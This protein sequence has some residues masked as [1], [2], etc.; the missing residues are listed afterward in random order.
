MKKLVGFIIVLLVIFGIFIFIFFKKSNYS[1]SYKIDDVKVHENYDKKYNS[2][3]INLEYKGKK[4]AFV[5]NSKYVNKRKLI[6]NVKIEKGKDLVCLDAESNY[7]DTYPVCIKKDKYVAYDY[8]NKDEEIGK[9]NN[10][11]IYDYDDN[12]FLLW[13]YHNFI[14][15]DKDTK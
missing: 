15:L 3:L 9:K 11:T 5:S 14:Y 2:Y 1:L 8:K 10:I 13:N 12:K 7:I 4:F 6:K